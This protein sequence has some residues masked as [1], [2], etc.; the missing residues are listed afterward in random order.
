[1]GRLGMID[2]FVCLF[3]LVR[4]IR[5][6]AF[7]FDMGGSAERKLTVQLWLVGLEDWSHPTKIGKRFFDERAVVV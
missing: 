1:M 5:F 6:D 4:R 3:L 2:E 7:G